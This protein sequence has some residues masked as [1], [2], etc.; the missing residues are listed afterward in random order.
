MT[1][2]RLTASRRLDALSL[3]LGAGAITASVASRTLA[4]PVIRYGQYGSTSAGRLRVR[5]GADLRWPAD[6]SAAKLTLE[7][8]R[9]QPRG[10]LSSMV[11]DGQTIRVSAK[12]GSG[13][14]GDAALQEATDQ[15]RDGFSIDLVNAELDGD[16]IIAGD[17]IAVGQV[18]I[19]AFDGMRIDTIA[20]NNNPTST[21]DNSMTKAQRARL[22]V[23]TGMST[24][25]ADEEAEFSRLSALA[26]ANPDPATDTDD[27][28]AAP[29]AAAAA[30][31][32]APA[33]APVPVAAS[34]PAV[35]AGVPRP[36]QSGQSSS[37]TTTTR[38]PNLQS[39]IRT[40]TAA[41]SPG[42][43]GANAIQAA[44]AD[45][46]NT[47]NPA[48]EAPAWSGELWSG[49]AY[50]AEWTPL[51]NAGD[52][53]SFEGKGWRFT[54]RPALQDYAGDK[55]EIPT[56]TV[57]TE[58][59][60][61]TAARVALG[62]D[63]DRKFFDFP[64]EGFLNGILEAVRESWA[65]ISDAKVRAYALAEAAANPLGGGTPVVET[66]LL[67]AAA[68]AALAVKRARLGRATFIAVNDNDLMDLM[69][70]TADTLPA[71]LDLWGI[72]PRQFVSAAEVPAGKVIAGVK[73]SATYRTL[74]G[75]PIRVDAQ[76]LTRAGVDEAFFGYWAIEQHHPAGIVQVSF[77]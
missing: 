52:L 68:R 71:F 53:T 45:I 37:T 36:G 72:D 30:A 3:N 55:A 69:D 70:V 58:S 19:P 42:G 31:P 47:A 18:G 62:Y 32:A 14:E 20:A 49:V 22:S 41:L 34:V 5:P 46:T 59:A 38:G 24:R 77:T 43:G 48:V 4:G 16:W 2:N 12:V 23:L 1:L 57:G 17:V 27:A 56:G 73:S 51:F 50:E 64:N 75:S 9:S 13:P 76:N 67:R 61:Y 21:G 66:S 25:T 29:A 6:L 74:P 60:S 28:P 40:V 54:T 7:H 26:V 15:V 44:L 10:Y 8:D 33:P 39:F 35:T 11:D 65:I 63:I